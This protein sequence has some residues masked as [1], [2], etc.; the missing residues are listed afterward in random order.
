M[1][2]II[3]RFLKRRKPFMLSNIQFDRIIASLDGTG[4]YVIKASELTYW[5]EKIV[6]EERR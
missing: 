2:S 5:I 6:N 4:G 1:R 3:R